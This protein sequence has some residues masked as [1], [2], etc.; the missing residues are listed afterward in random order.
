MTGA[1]SYTAP[2]D[3]KMRREPVPSASTA[4]VS[5]PPRAMEVT[6]SYWFVMLAA[7][8]FGT[9]VGDLWAE[10]L[11]PGPITS[12]VSLLAICAAAVWYH[13]RSA[14]RTE[15][16]YW[17]AI[18][19]MRAAATNVAD[20]STHQLALGYVTVSVLLFVLTLIAARFASP[21]FSRSGSP[22]V[23]GVYWTAMF[24]AGVFG[25]VAGD[26]IHHN[27]GLYNASGALCFLLAGLILIRE[28]RAPV[29][30]LL[31]WLIVMAE[32]CAGTAVGDALASHR[33]AGLGVPI[34]SV[35]TGALTITCLWLRARLSRRW[36]R[37]LVC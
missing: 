25:T 26:L 16:G 24:I 31:F 4:A 11:F 6:R 12:L 10:T 23:D 5:D 36:Q 30:M 3:V 9:N 7:S 27:I 15:V 1:L 33:A 2:M 8:A 34:A 19:A 29:S 28:A 20:I 17:V 18:V 14:A 32:R 21:D 22:R 13:R 37:G 35:C